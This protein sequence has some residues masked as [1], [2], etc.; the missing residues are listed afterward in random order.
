MSRFE[1]DWS[2]LMRAANAGD[3]AAYDRLL[4]DLSKA[5]RPQVRA[6]LLRAGQRD[7]DPEDIVQEIL[8][9]VHLKRHTWKETEPF[10]PWVRAVAHYKTV[11]AM[12]R[13]GW[14][15]HVPIDDFVETL[16]A[17]EP[18]PQVS[19]RDVG[20]K[21]EQLPS[22]QRDVVQA[23]TIAGESIADAARRLDMTPGA[24]RVALHR[25]LAALARTQEP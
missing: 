23:V 14:R 5:L 21:L 7:L 18:E 4:R 22:R 10:S 2:E 9:A 19:D 8:L 15:V 13:R 12:R 11:D 24:V 3:A 25:G 6:A 17:S 1:P 20:R 16:A